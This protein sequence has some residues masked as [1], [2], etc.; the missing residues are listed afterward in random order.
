MPEAAEP[1]RLHQEQMV[2]MF[3][4]RWFSKMMCAAL[5][6]FPC[7]ELAV[8]PHFVW[9]LSLTIQKILIRVWFLILLPFRWLEISTSPRFLRLELPTRNLSCLSMASILMFQVEA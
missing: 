8:L 1:H 5:A 9:R 2:M 6:R 3:G 7:R 4:M